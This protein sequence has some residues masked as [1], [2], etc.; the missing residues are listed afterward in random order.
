MANFYLERIHYFG[1]LRGAVQ[2]SSTTF[3]LFFVSREFALGEYIHNY[4]LEILGYPTYIIKFVVDSFHSLLLS[5]LFP[6]KLE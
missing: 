3:F 1:L 2:T 5:I 6:L 4:F